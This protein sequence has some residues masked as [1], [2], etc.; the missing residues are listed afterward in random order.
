M[1]QH[2]AA[3]GIDPNHPC[4]EEQR[5]WERIAYETRLSTGHE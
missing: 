3:L 4:T 1:K 5:E 2:G